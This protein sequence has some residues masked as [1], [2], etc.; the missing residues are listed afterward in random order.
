M[1]KTRHCELCKY[2]K[3]DLKN[4]LT[5]GLTDRKPDFKDFCSNLKFSNDFKDYLPELLEKIELVN[6]KKTSVYI[7]FTLFCVI[8]LA[9][10]IGSYSRLEQTFKM[11]FNHSSWHYFIGTFLIFLIGTFF[12]STGYQ[13]L[14]KHKKLLKKL[15]SDKEEID[16]VIKNYKSDVEKI[17]NLEK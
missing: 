4:G 1:I 9:I 10:I 12:I 5:C 6:K 8:G 15:K 13:N 16:M 11:E 2:P 14:Y 3:R 7:S 17:I